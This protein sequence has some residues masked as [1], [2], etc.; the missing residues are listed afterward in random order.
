M[1]L[2]FAIAMRVEKIIGAIQCTCGGP[3]LVQANPNKPIT[4]RGATVKDVNIVERVILKVG[5]IYPIAT[6]ITEL[7]VGVHLGP[8]HGLCNAYGTRGRKRN[9][10]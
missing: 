1:S 9:M 5:Q 7:L 2:T 6:S 8:V 3:K 4:R 10:Q